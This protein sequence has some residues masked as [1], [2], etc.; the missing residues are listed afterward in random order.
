MVSNVTILGSNSAMPAFGRL[1][2]SHYLQLL[3][4]T[5]LIDCGEG[6]QFALYNQ[7][8]KKN[9]ISKIFITHLHGD[10][11]F[12]LPGLLTSFELSGRK[13]P[14]FIFGPAPIK[15]YIAVSLEG[16]GHQVSYS[17]EIQELTDDCKQLIYENEKMEIYSFPLIHRI[18][19]LGYLFKEKPK[20]RN[21]K[22]EIIEKHKP[23]IEQIKAL[24][25]G[26]DLR[27]SN[28]K[29]I[30]NERCLEAAKK[31]R[32]YAYCSDTRY[33][34][35]L[36]EHIEGVTTLYHEATYLDELQIQANER[37][38]ST[39]KQA[40]KIAKLANVEQLIIGHYSSRYKDIEPFKIEAK[41]EFQNVQLAKE[42]RN[43]LI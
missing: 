16:I 15:K 7:G 6:T 43:I 34:E 30:T 4:H 1:P 31:T 3:N 5:F 10:H 25:S 20:R 21:I 14:L 37:Y 19:C 33:H 26:H 42:G 32:S 28:G 22:R 9:K 11:L 24:I 29:I 27:L 35:E 38:H 23:T 18:T 2:S 12:G 8:L 41:T 13:E 17:I 40:G 36:V 39:S